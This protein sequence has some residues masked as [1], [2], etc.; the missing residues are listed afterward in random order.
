MSCNFKDQCVEN[1]HN[2]NILIAL[3]TTS[4]AILRLY[5]MLDKLGRAVVYFDTDSIHYIDNG[6]SKIKSGTMLGEW[7]DELGEDVY[8]TDWATTGP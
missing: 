3:F 8:I 4:S 6:V 5:E 2:T 1:H 7:N